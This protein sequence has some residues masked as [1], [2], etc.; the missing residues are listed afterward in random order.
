MKAAKIAV[1]V[2]LSI[3]F[4]GCT[5]VAEFAKEYN[6]AVRAREQREMEARQEQQQQYI[7]TLKNRCEQY[8]A[9]EG[10]SEM[11]GC[12]LRLQQIDAQNAAQNAAAYQQSLQNAARII[13]ESTTPIM[14]PQPTDNS[15]N[16]RSYRNGNEIV[17]NCR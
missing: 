4:N 9:R 12:V 8:G 10:S 5:G 1:V 13:R 2:V 16:C 15:M 17:T 3:A 7:A 6:A 14:V 11:V